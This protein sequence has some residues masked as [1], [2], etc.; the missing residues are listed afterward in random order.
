MRGSGRAAS[1]AVPKAAEHGRLGGRHVG[2]EAGRRF[3]SVLTGAADDAK[4]V[5]Y[6]QVMQ[7]AN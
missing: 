3:E 6:E 7:L 1:D 5:A 4:Q 2:D